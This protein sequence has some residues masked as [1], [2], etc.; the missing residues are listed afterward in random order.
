[1]WILVICGL[2]RVERFTWAKVIA[3]AV[4]MVG[5]VL[6]AKA[7][8]S[9]SPSPE[10]PVA[11]HSTRG[12]LKTT[13]EQTAGSIFAGDLMALL[14]AFFYG[15]NTTLLKIR[16][17]D[18]SRI[19]M[20]LLFGFS[21]LINLIV[22]F[23]GIIIFHLLGWERFELPAE[24]KVWLLLGINFVMN[25]ASD[26]SWAYAMLLTTPLLVT[27]GLSMTIPLALLAQIILLGKVVGVWY[28]FGACLVF[29]A[30]FIVNH[31]SEAEEL[32]DHKGKRRAT[33]EELTGSRE[34]E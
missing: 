6:V 1:M 9:S 15:I 13:I 23:P 29:G 19:N 17:G 3:V 2:L 25:V 26:Y 34:S 24:S 33:D 4:S 18:E 10:I 20:Q 31:E 11:S 27:M 5:I 30:F 8:I 7:D 12:F 28:W 14:G 32:E 21:G 16:I 22:L